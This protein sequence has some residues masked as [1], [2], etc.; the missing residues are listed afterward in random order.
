MMATTHHQHGHTAVHEGDHAGGH[1]KHE[2][3][4]PEMFRDRLWV[5]LAL[6]FPILYF[7]DQIQEWFN[8]A[9][10]TFA[11]SAWISPVLATFLFVYAGSV[12]LKGAQREL[13]ERLPGMMTLISLAISVAYVY[14]VAVSL[15]LD[16]KPF[17]WEL[18]TLLDVML[19]G[20]WMEMKSIQSASTALQH[21]ADMV[22]QNAH[23]VASTGTVA[24]V[25]VASLEN[26]DRILIRPGEQVPADGEIVEGRSSMNEAFLTGESRPASKGEGDEVIAGAVNGEGA[27]TVAITRTGEAT[28]LSQIM[29]LVE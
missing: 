5:S 14:S 27:L 29:R 6:T 22:P 7:S 3:H 2:G 13:Q 4:S 8:Y 17:Y 18:A 28:T 15:G 21:L 16:G 11:G 23:L 19:L 12:F 10:V 9:G 1:D 26:G 24:E 20:H 25:P